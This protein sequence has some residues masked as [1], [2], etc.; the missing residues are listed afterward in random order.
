VVSLLLA[1]GADPNIVNPYTTQ[2]PLYYAIA[3]GHQDVVRLLLA[4][5]GGI[6]KP[7]LG[8]V[9][10]TPISWA[11]RVACLVLRQRDCD[12]SRQPRACTSSKTNPPSSPDGGTVTAQTGGN[13][14][15]ASKKRLREVSEFG[16]GGGLGGSGND[17]NKQ[18][19]SCSTPSSSSN[20]PGLRLACPY[21]KYDP[22]RYGS[23]K[24]CRGPG[25]WPSINRLK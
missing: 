23:Q 12:H 10:D 4:H 11:D 14:K 17:P 7:T 15:N 19:T 1:H 16:S 2:M 9:P 18:P 25:G 21:Y 20:G 3:G 5:G 24:P 13:S 6:Q 22:G 8:P